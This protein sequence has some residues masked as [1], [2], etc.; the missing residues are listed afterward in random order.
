MN[1]Y[2]MWKKKM[3]NMIIAALA[4]HGDE[5]SL[6]QERLSQDARDLIAWIIREKIPA[7]DLIQMPTNVVEIR[8]GDDEMSQLFSE[9]R[10]DGDS[11]NGAQLYEQAR[12]EIE[13]RSAE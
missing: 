5:K 4:E 12:K 3:T 9:V 6:R 1:A 11:D 2:G 10:C 8:I 13:A 7:N